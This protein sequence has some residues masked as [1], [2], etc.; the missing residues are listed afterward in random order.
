MKHIAF[1]IGPILDPV[2]FY[3]TEAKREESRVEEYRSNKI[4]RGVEGSRRYGVLVRHNVKR[5]WE[6]LGIWNPEWGFAGRN[7]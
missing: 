2:D 3:Y 7:V 1:D 5:R 6:K 4:F